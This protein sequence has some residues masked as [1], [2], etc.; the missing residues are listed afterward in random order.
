MSA[1]PESRSYEEALTRMLVIAQAQWGPWIRSYWFYEEDRCPGC[2]GPL[3]TMRIQGQEAL[4][5]NVFIYRQRGVLIGYFLCRRCAGTLFMAA[6]KRP[7]TQTGLHV[8][9]EE[10]LIQAYERHLA[11]ASDA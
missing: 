4:S 1:V 10:R 6:H 7:G 3:D 2:E 8:R 9:I 11:A 5:L